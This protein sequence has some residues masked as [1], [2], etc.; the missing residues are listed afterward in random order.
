MPSY[1]PLCFL[2]IVTLSA[3]TFGQTPDMT[4]P[5]SAKVPRLTISAGPFAGISFGN[6]GHQSGSDTA[7]VSSKSV[8]GGVRVSPRW[9]VFNDGYGVGFSSSMAWLESHQISSTNWYDG[10]LAGRYYLGHA[11]ASQAWLDATL[12][13]MLAVEHLDAYRSDTGTWVPKRSVSDWAPAASLALGYDALGRSFGVTVEARLSYYGL[14]HSGGIFF[15]DA[16]TVATL[17]LSLVGCGFH[18]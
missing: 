12:G 16:Q 18:H 3:N 17:G 11:R 2:A 4:R 13:A 10:Q 5:A 14:N 7:V 6:Q 15:Y 8:I 1:T 9:R